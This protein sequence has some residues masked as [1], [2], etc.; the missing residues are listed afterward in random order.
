M[1]LSS[2]QAELL[3][4]PTADVQ[5]PERTRHGARIAHLP[6]G[7]A[8]HGLASATWDDW[9]LAG[10]LSEGWTVRWQ[11]S[12]RATLAAG[13][14]LILV[15]IAGY[16]WGL[17]LVS[18]AAVALT[19]SH[20]DQAV[21]QSTRESLE[22]RWLKPS[23]LSLPEQSRVRRLF[24]QAVAATERLSSQAADW[25]EP[26][27]TLHLRASTIGP[28]ALA[29]PDGSIVLTDELVEL[30]RGHDGALLGVMAHEMAHVRQRHAMR[31]LVQSGILAA[32]AG[33]IWGDFS[34]LLATGPVLLGH[35]AYSRDF[36]RDADS[37][38][39]ELLKAQG[40]RPSVMVIFFDKMR[41]QHQATEAGVA[42]SSHPMD[43]ERIARFRDS[44]R[45]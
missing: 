11:Q 36:E 9:A 7:G 15:S 26:S 39:I 29:L 13:L 10:G 37:H 41:G 34:S 33:A 5:W 40:I 2:E 8:I 23:K 42:S 27:Y 6:S 14:A 18:A 35:L 19:P 12:W 43:D 45:D 24:E 20:I 28:N 32:V 3:A 4:V 44:D 38:A 1:V 17:P 22:G 31:L 16:R 25:R 21:G 30:L